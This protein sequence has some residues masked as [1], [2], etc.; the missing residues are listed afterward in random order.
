VKR[1]GTDAL[2]QGGGALALAILMFAT[3]WYGETGAPPAAFTAP[4][5]SSAGAWQTLGAVRW[6]LVATL[7]V[8]LASALASAIT[9]TGALTGSGALRS[10]ALVLA[11][12]SVVALFIRVLLVPPSGSVDDI[13]IGGFLALISVAVI[14]VGAKRPPARLRARDAANGETRPKVA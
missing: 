11:L 8:A 12:A 13:K 7:I 5:A 10:A 4:I 1:L 9:R 2:L 6:L 14:A 3:R